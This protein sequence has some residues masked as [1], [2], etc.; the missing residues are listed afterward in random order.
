[1]KEYNYD[2]AEKD[3]F[4]KLAKLP[5][6]LHYHNLEHTKDVLEAVKRLCF[7]EGVL[8]DEFLLLKTAALYH[9]TGYLID[10]KKHEEMGV[11]IAK[12]ILPSYQYDSRD[13]DKI[14]G[15]ILATKMPQAPKTKLQKII[16]DA[17][18]DN[19][20]R[21]DFYVKG[22]LLRLEFEKQGVTI[23]PRAWYE[24]SINLL[25]NHHYF[26]DAA[27]RLRDKGKEKHIEEI[28]ELLKIK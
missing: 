25:E 8:G 22:E 1:M 6:T 13:I 15:I 17:D 4:G 2:R 3:A 27:K 19:L 11:R 14:S 23:P 28:K 5:K 21:E 9:D 16:C 26:T 20:G 7:F 18:L 12:S 10:P 24:N